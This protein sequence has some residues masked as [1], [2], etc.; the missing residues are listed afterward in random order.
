[1]IDV[2][3][4]RNLGTLLRVPFRAR[5]YRS[6]LNAFRTCEDPIDVLRR[7]ATGSGV[8]PAVIKLRTPVGSVN[9]RVYSWHDTR[10]IYEIFLSEDYRTDTAPKIIV[11]FGS[12]IGVSAAFFL[13]RSD[14]LVA[15]LFEPVPINAQRLRDNLSQFDERFTL[16]QVALWTKPQ[17]KVRFGTENSGRYGGIGLETESSI[18]V[19]ACESNRVLMDIIA[20]HGRIDVLKIDVETME[21]ALVDHLT[22]ALA[23]QIRIIHVEYRFDENVLSETH[24]MKIHGTISTFSLRV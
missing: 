10:T 12:N 19:E 2:S 24:D 11:D 1:M 3:R 14:D 6:V 21:R 7:Y 18:E 9:L 13:T 5:N 8:Y 16:Y 22:V 23:K 4:S 17:G 15:Y 20:K